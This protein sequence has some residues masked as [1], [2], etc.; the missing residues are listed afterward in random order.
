MKLHSLL[1]FSAVLLLSTPTLLRAEVVDLTTVS[2]KTYRQC[3]IIKI[4]TDGV[5]FRHASGAGKVLFKDMT[6]NWRDHFGFDPVKARAQE[7]KVATER[8]KAREIALQRAHEAAKARQE[9]FERQMEAQALANFQNA[10]AQ[11]N[12]SYLTNG[13]VA[14]SGGLPTSGIGPA[15]DGRG[16]YQAGRGYHSYP[17]CVGNVTGYNHLG[18][19]HG[20]HGLPHAGTRYFSTGCQTGFNTGFTPRSFFAVPGVGI[21]AAP[22]ACAPVFHGSHGFAPV[23][24]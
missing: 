6:K 9:A 4:E 5:M 17:G 20:H 24:R 21:N 3:R 22:Q 14:I 12:A 16:Y 10:L 8:K 1:T 7:E 13:W 11:N 15:V 19:A 2:G 18:R 23:G